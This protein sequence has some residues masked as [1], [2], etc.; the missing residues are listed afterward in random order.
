TSLAF[1]F[2]LH[3]ALPSCHSVIDRRTFLGGT[4]AMLLA[5][6]LAAEAK[7]QAAKVYRIGWMIGSSIP[8]SAH[9]IDAFKEGKNIEYE[10]RAAEDR[11]ST[12]LNYSKQII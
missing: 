11:K 5:V 4:G 6:P 10:I 3:T 12:R 1:L 7:Q 8:A 2:T 9:L